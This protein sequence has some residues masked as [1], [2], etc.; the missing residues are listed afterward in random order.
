MSIPKTAKLQNTKQLNMA[1]R[2]SGKIDRG[3]KQL[4]KRRGKKK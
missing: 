3:L 2:R 4:A 1:V